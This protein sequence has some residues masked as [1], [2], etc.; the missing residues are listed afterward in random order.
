MDQIAWNQFVHAHGSPSGRFLQSWE[1]GEFQRAVGESVRRET[2]EEEGRIVGVGQWVDRE[3]RGLWEYAFCPKGPIMTLTVPLRTTETPLLPNGGQG[4]VASRFIFLR[5][6]P[7]SFD[8]LG[9]ARKTL[10]INPAHTFITDLSQA[11]DELLAAMH[12]KTRYNIGVARRHGVEVELDSKDFDGVWRLLNETSARDGFRLHPKRYYQMMLDSI[13]GNSCNVF[14]SIVRK[15][16]Q[17]LAC[18]IVVDF[19]DTR[20]YLHGASSNEDRNVMAPYLL[21]WEL[22]LRAKARGLRYYDWWGVAPQ[23][24]VSHPWAGISRFK[25]GFGGMEVSAPG[26]YD[27]VLKPIA[28]KTFQTARAFARFARRFV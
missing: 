27:V 25:R 10:D 7:D 17:A 24:V 9:G 28:Y 22:M 21:H 13:R 26:T 2:Y 11:E 20:T 14:L 15:A 4:G 16:S 3:M 23:S 5:I 6:E 12:P 19:G 8:L 1:W 18:A